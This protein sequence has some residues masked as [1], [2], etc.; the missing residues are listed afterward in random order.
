MWKIWFKS[1]NSLQTGVQST[2]KLRKMERK[3]LYARMLRKTTSME[4]SINAF[5]N[6]STEP[7]ESVVYK[8][9]F[10]EWKNDLDVLLIVKWSVVKGKLK[11][12]N[13]K[14]GAKGRETKTWIEKL[15]KPLLH[16]VFLVL[17]ATIF[18][19]I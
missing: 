3:K 4:I 6:G 19:T 9:H 14:G 8:Y 12:K 11:E 1:L 15:L 17:F 18:A 2:K 10:L 5:G 13:S 16:T 7:R